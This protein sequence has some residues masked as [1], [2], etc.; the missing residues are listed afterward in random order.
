MNYEGMGR[1]ILEEFA[2]FGAPWTH[3]SGFHVYDPTKLA[4]TMAAWRAA[5]PA[6]VKAIA[7]RSK[8][9]DRAKYLAQKKAQGA[10]YRARHPEYTDANRQ[11]MAKRRAKADANGA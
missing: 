9:K 1:D 3:H 7:K 4:E 8:A 10:R 6:R 11:R 5:N 2:A